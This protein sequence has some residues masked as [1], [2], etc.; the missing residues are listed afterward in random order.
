M[1]KNERFS[2]ISVVVDR[3]LL[4][5][6]VVIKWWP[7]EFLFFFFLNLKDQYEHQSYFGCISQTDSL[8]VIDFVLSK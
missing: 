8:I 7:S 5:R 2:V 6:S 1:N 3:V 4:Y